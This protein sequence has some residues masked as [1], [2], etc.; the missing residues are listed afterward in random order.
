MKI[1]FDQKEDTTLPDITEKIKLPTYFSQ[2]TSLLEISLLLP[3]TN[4]VSEQSRI[5]LRRIKN[6][7]RTSMTQGRL[8]HCMLLAIDK[9]MTEKLSLIYVDANEFYFGSDE[10]SRLFSRFCQ[11]Q[12]P[13]LTF[14]LQ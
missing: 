14:T 12:L 9:E 10:R 13:F 4:P 3:A 6:W 11:N 1:Y 5:T 7:L 8:S 2:V